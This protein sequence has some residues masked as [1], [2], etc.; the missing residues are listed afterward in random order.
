MASQ[1][2][3]SVRDINAHTLGPGLSESPRPAVGWKPRGARLF[4]LVLSAA[5]LAAL[6]RSIDIRL[7]VRDLRSVDRVWL[8]MSVG[9]IVPIT[10]LSAICFYLV[11]LR[12]TMPVIG[13]DVWFAFVESV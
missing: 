7:I 12:G 2:S 9:M 8:V 1:L 6:Y 10:W 13:E 5:I 4:S 11:A 3:R